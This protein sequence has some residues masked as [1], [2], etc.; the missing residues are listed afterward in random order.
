MTQPHK[1]NLSKRWQRKDSTNSDRATPN[2]SS[3]SPNKN[4]YVDLADLK[5]VAV[6]IA[7]NFNCPTNLG[8]EA[9]VF[10]CLENLSISSASINEFKLFVEKIQNNQVR[11]NVTENLCQHN[12]IELGISSTIAEPAAWLEIYE[13]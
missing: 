3:S 1:I 11:I 10:F 9:K 8:K 5:N 6:Q 7:R 12:Q 2:N 13:T 4:V